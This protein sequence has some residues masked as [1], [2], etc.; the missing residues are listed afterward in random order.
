MVVAEGF[1][2]KE[3]DPKSSRDLVPETDLHRQGL[4]S[5]EIKRGSSLYLIL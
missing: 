4:Q 2:R 1:E 5:G 3:R